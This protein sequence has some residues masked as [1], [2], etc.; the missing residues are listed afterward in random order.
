ARNTSALNGSN[1]QIQ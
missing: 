1:E